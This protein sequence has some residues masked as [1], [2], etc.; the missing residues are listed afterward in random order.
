MPMYIVNNNL[1]I[2][3]MILLMLIIYWLNKIH[4]KNINKYLLSMGTLKDMSN[5]SIVLTAP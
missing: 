3:I 2:I 1:L 5:V 4:K